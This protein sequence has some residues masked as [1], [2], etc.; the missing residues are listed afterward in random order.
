MGREAKLGKCFDP[1]NADFCNLSANKEESQYISSMGQWNDSVK[2]STGQGPCNT[3]N[4]HS[5]GCDG[6]TISNP[7]WA[8]TGPA[9]GS[10]MLIGGVVKCEKCCSNSYECNTCQTNQTVT[11]TPEITAFK[12]DDSGK[13][14]GEKCCEYNMDRRFL[15]PDA[16]PC[17]SDSDCARIQA[18][19]QID[20]DLKCRTCPGYGTDKKIGGFCCSKTCFALNRE[21]AVSCPT[22]F[23]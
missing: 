12:I 16:Y 14:T 10:L 23:P 22:P 20:S 17:M 19:P 21:K 4:E 18:N 15:T 11:I 3:C 5:S 8:S 2:M 9:S 6:C 13:L 1:E 7:V